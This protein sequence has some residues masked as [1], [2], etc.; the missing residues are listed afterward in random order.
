MLRKF[1]EGRRDDFFTLWQQYVPASMLGL[2]FATQ[3]LEFYLQVYFA[4][5][6]A[7]PSSSVL[8]AIPGTTVFGST[9]G[10]LGFGAPVAALPPA[11]SPSPGPSPTLG[12]TAAGGGGGTSGGGS[13]PGDG[14]GGG[15]HPHGAVLSHAGA[16]HSHA[17]LHGHGHGHG[18]PAA[19]SSRHE[20]GVRMKV[21]KS[22]LE[23]RGASLAQTTEFLPYYALP[24]VPQPEHHPCFEGLFAARWAETQRL[25]LRAFL[26]DIAVREAA[27]VPLLYTLYEQHLDATGPGPAPPS[28]GLRAAGNSERSP[29]G[30][31]DSRDN[32]YGGE[33]GRDDPED[34]AAEAEEMAEALRSPCDNADAQ[35]L[36]GR[37]SAAFDGQ[38]PAAAAGASAGAYVPSG[39]ELT[40]RQRRLGNGPASGGNSL[41]LSLGALGMS[42]SAVLRDSVVL[43]DGDEEGDG[44]G[45]DEDHAD[46]AGGDLG[47]GEDGGSADDGAGGSLGEGDGDGGFGEGEGKGSFGEG[48]SGFGEGEGGFG[49]GE[50]E[51][52]T[53]GAWVP[54]DYATVKRD[55]QGRDPGL[56]ARLLQ[57]L[58]WRLLRS[59]PG[60]QRTALL[61]SW[62][63]A[64]LLGAGPQSAADAQQLAAALEEA[65]ATA[66]PQVTAAATA[67]PLPPT[68]RASGNVT[69]ADPP[70]TR[71]VTAATPPLLS[72]QHPQRRS[73]LSGAASASASASASSAAA[74]S[75][76]ATLASCGDPRVEEEV[77]RLACAIACERLGRS[78]LLSLAAPGG[79]PGGAVAALWR[80][81]LR[82]VRTMRG[83]AVG[84]GGRT[85][86]AEAADSPSPPRPPPLP[87]L[88]TAGLYAL[89]GLQK[90]S[91]RRGA[92]SGL[93]GLGAVGWLVWFLQDVDILYDPMTIEYGTAL[94]LN[95]VLRSAGRADAAP[96]AVGVPLLRL[97]EGLLQRP[98]LD[99]QVRTYLAG[100][101]FSA[102]RQ[103]AIRDAALSRGTGD[104]LEG[105]TAGSGSGA[106]AADRAFEEQVQQILRQLYMPD[107]ELEPGPDPDASA[108]DDDLDPD[109]D[110]QPEEGAEEPADPYADMEV[111]PEAP[112]AQPG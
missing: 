42:E 80:L 2:D 91:V 15:A 17:H 40:L 112:E 82:L 83:T 35:C 4:I 58:R 89:M 46:D 103:P 109:L 81:L 74:P 24:Y 44:E 68:R 73:A 14:G 54:L 26:E 52:G 50:V 106:A 32:E 25:A 102:F 12:G 105:L 93:I 71:P 98:R 38:G 62:A 63:E 84:G 108:A 101:L 18:S 60:R 41:A 96:P 75:L 13:G 37:D 1:D 107:E 20:L 51:V 94:L 95:L 88:P 59:T 49:E 66:A 10:P 27:A 85:S 67:P 34:E 11:P 29:H 8:V 97:C 23:G 16:V 30:Q 43:L 78:Y 100:I 57:A 70:V 76:L 36:Y 104:L 90:L 99:E 56:A 72:A 69:F 6:P 7:L 92:Q 55:L 22:Y 87:P 9:G 53:S 3:K 45:A 65:E 79:G 61:A 5:Y 111:A 47:E 21:F 110:P 48:D 19:S 33:Y 86:L 39:Q 77:A 31:Y 64:D 28:G